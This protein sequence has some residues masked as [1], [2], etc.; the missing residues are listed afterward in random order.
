[1][2]VTLLGDHDRLRQILLNLITNAVKFTERGR[3]V[4]GAR[5]DPDR[6]RL[7]LSVS[8]TGIGIAPDKLPFLFGR[9]TQA[10][11]SITRRYGG[12]GLGLAISKRLVELMGGE[13]GVESQ[14]GHGSTFWFEIPLS[15]AEE[16]PAALPNVARTAR[17]LQPRH[18]L[19]AEDNLVD[20]QIITAMIE[21]AGHRVT[22]VGHGAA[23]VA[24]ARSDAFDVILMDIQMPVMDGLTAA[25]AIRE[26]EAAEDRRA[27][28]IIGLT[29]NAMSEEI[30][31]CREAGM[32]AHVA[33]PIDWTELFATLDTIAA[34]PRSREA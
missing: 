3:I 5:Y 23:A 30:A 4:V 7:R 25:R 12:T 34:P 21:N 8:D 1:M 24:G 31:R 13:I 33:K 29:A 19:L 11:T 27:T 28:P 18:V 32:D 20:Q 10:D 9:F 15:V 6:T 14:A 2:P 26:A 16:L 22:A 17:A